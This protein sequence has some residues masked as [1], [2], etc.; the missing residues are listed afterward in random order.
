MDVKEKTGGS[1]RGRRR[2][3]RPSA[4][5]PAASRLSTL[6][7]AVTLAA[8]GAACAANPPRE[9]AAGIADRRLTVSWEDASAGAGGYVIA[10]RPDNGIVPFTWKEYDAASSPWTIADL[11]AMSGWSYEVRVA[12]AAA[13]EQWS[14]TVT[15]TAPVLQPAP[16][17]SIAIQAPAPHAVGDVV[18]SVSG[19]A[20]VRP[21]RPISNRSPRRW[22]L[23]SANGTDCKLLPRPRTVQ[24]FHY[25]IRSEMRGKLLRV[26]VDYDQDGASWSATADMSIAEDAPRLRRPIPPPPPAV[27]EAS[28]AC[29]EP[30]GAAE[31]GTTGAAPDATT[32][33]THLHALTVESVRFATRRADGNGGAVAALCDDLLVV[34]AWG[35]LVLLSD[36]G[37]SPLDGQVPMV[38]DES[39]VVRIPE[40]AT[41]HRAFD[42]LLFRVS[43]ILLAPQSSDRWRLFVTH[44]YADGE[45][46]RFRLSATA[47][48]REGRRV[49]VSPTWTTVS[50]LSP[51]AAYHSGLIAGGRMLSDGP[52]HLLVALGDFADRAQDP[53]S[54]W[55]KLLRVDVETGRTEV[56]AAGLRNPQGL[57]RDTDGV[58]W[59]TEHGPR[60]GDELNVL[61]AGAN[62]GWPRVSHGLAYGRRILDAAGRTEEGRHDGFSSPVFF[63]APAIAVSSVIVNDARFFPLWGNDLLV[64]SLG[65]TAAVHRIRRDGTDVKSVER[66]DVGHAVRDMAALP[67]GRIALFDGAGLVLFLSRS[68]KHCGR[69]EYRWDH[70]Y[71]LHCPP[72]EASAPPR[73]DW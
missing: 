16:A 65:L 32:I 1:E 44:Q 9:V 55:G 56:L 24:D 59:E 3:R 62:Y 70:V 73:G 64:G 69:E 29:P 58:L 51:C 41:R 28:R 19:A 61:E 15:A 63:W 22:S 31:I 30:P 43:D 52:N 33:E 50:D 17:G 27:V 68:R 12:F 47:I 2:G 26:Q 34:T 4:C 6:A 49:I 67:D 10:V 25:M 72:P 5:V 60:G 42:P 66:I 45:C 21:G 71:S 35:R 48:R 23:C 54:T 20:A 11:W 40:L 7:A 36:S 39:D 38:S 37:A 14:P 18:R 8:F 57:A 13:D 46:L 53:R